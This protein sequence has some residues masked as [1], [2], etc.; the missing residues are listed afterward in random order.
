LLAIVRIPLGRESQGADRARAYVALE[1]LGAEQELLAIVGSW[2][3]TLCDAD[4]LS[5]LREYMQP[6]E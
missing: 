4:V 2:C 6:G 3:D 1:R 5:M